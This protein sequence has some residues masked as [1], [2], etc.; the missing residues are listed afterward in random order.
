[1]F[2][3]KIES[4][5]THHS[6]KLYDKPPDGGFGWFIVA[7]HFINIGIG[8][9]FTKSFGLFMPYIRD[10]FNVDNK[11]TSMIWA[12]MMFFQYSGSLIGTGGVLE[13][14]YSS[15]GHKYPQ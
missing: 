14:I 6:E 8:Y 9:G 15:N 10:Q 4:F 2:T 13:L 7:G 3:L 11:T 5:A 1:M 12:M